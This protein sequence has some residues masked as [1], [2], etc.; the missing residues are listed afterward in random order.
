MGQGL[1]SRVPPKVRN[2]VRAKN[3]AQ[4]VTVQIS[5]LV[6][7]QFARVSVSTSTALNDRRMLTI[8]EG[9]ISQA[10]GQCSKKE[11]NVDTNIRTQCEPPES[12]EPVKE[13]DVSPDSPA[14]TLC[15]PN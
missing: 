10:G 8:A 13:S 5:D 6:F 9:T 3:Q 15:L 7:P 12:V 4:G 1:H 11:T 14:P 2:I